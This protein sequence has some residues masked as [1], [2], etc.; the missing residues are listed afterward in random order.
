VQPVDD[1]DTHHLQAPLS[2][3]QTIKVGK[4]SV[5]LMSSDASGDTVRI[6]NGVPRD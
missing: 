2:P 6:I 4:V 1:S 3:G 5:E